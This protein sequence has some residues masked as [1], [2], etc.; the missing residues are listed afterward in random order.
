MSVRLGFRE[1]LERRAMEEGWEGNGVGM[2]R[3]ME[4]YEQ[5]LMLFTVTGATLFYLLLAWAL[6]HHFP[7]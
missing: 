1:Y 2:G 6:F 5:Y 7:N 4:I 3:A